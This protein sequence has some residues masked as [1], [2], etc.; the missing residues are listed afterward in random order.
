VPLIDQIEGSLKDSAQTGEV[1]VLAH[2]IGQVAG[3]GA[4][5]HALLRVGDG[6]SIG[7]APFL[8][9]GGGIQAD[10]EVTLYAGSHR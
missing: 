5:L 3:D 1:D 10:A 9:G 7:E 2:P 8:L 4:E 6:V